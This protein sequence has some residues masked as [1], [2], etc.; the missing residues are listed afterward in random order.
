MTK[1]IHAD[2]RAELWRAIVWCVATTTVFALLVDFYLLHEKRIDGWGA[3]GIILGGVTLGVVTGT[4]IA[5]GSGWAAAGMV[6]TLTAGGDLTP[7]RSFSYEESLIASGRLNEAR[8]ALLAH[9]AREPRDLEA[10]LALASLHRDQL[11]DPDGAVRVLLDLRRRPLPSAIEFSVTNQLIDLHRATGDRGR[12]LAELA[13]FAERFKH[14]AAGA[15]ARAAL[16][17]IKAERA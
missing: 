6:N 12:E 15:Q 7:R 5:F 4:L 9:L 14:T 11:R 17:R 16:K 10:A 2:T 13:R 1:T 3:L 8:E